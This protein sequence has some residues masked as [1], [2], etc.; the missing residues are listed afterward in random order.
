MS[1]DFVSV[2]EAAEIKGV[3]RQRILQYINDGRLPAQKF[4][5]VYMIRRQDLD[6]VE[7]KP[8]GRPRKGQTEK[9]SKRQIKKRDK[10]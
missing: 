7:L 2:N 4:A 6:S 3:T 5:D 10:K 1:S 8:P 9:T